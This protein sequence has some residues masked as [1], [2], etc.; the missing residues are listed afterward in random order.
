MTFFFQSIA[1][2]Q[3]FSIIQ[4]CGNLESVISNDECRLESLVK[5]SENAGTQ[6]LLSSTSDSKNLRWYPGSS[7]FKSF[8]ED[9]DTWLWLMTSCHRLKCL[10]SWVANLNQ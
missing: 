8:T 10:G 5:L 1:I 9:S 2:L 6:A 7:N 4:I 3:I